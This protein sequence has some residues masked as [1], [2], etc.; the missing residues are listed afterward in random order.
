[1]KYL[2]AMMACGAMVW[3]PVGARASAVLFQVDMSV[4]E[5]EGN[6]AP[7]AGD[8]VVVRGSLAPLEWDGTTFPLAESVL[9]PGV[10]ETIVDFDDANA[11]TPVE[12]KFVM[13]PSGGADIWESVNNR[14]FLFEGEDK[15]LD[16]VYFDDLAGYTH[17]D[18]T[19]TFTVDQNDDCSSCIID[20][21]S[22]RGAVAPLSWDHD[23][24]LLSDNGDGTWSVSLLFPAGTTPIGSVAY[25]YR[26]HA[27]V[28]PE[29]F[30][31]LGDPCTAWDDATQW[32][33]Q[34]L[35]HTHPG[36]CF[37]NLGFDVDDGSPSITLPVDTWYP[38]AT[39][40]AG[41][42]PGIPSMPA[43]ISLA[44]NTPNPFNPA[45]V[46]RFELDARQSVTLTVYDLAGRQVECLL[47]GSF[48]AGRHSVGWRPKSLA[49]GTYIYRLRAGDETVQRSMVLLK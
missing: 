38:R 43:R 36:D 3:A 19:V 22:I 46:I 8:R 48:A 4:Q 6:F 44:Q 12:Y 11:G 14:T 21:I 2:L 40:V 27:D 41:D 23:D 17:E 24:Q 7:G 20:Q 39:G 31:M 18:V 26:A 35:R 45:T 15:I 30:D 28:K 37:A 32:M 9:D 10:Y 5:E 1:M 49:S 47:Q 29:R 42:Q 13:V 16:V 33:W 34:D 25:K